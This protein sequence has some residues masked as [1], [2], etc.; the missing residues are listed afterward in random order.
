MVINDVKNLEKRNAQTQGNG[1]R[2]TAT[3]YLN[4]AVDLI[5]NIHQT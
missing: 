4:D 1:R 2:L 5:K 3:G